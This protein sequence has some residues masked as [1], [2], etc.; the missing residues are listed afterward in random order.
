MA[1][2]RR[3]HVGQEIH[4]RPADEPSDRGSGGRLQVQRLCPRGE[5]RIPAEVRAG[6]RSNDR[7][8]AGRSD[9]VKRKVIGG[10]RY[11]KQV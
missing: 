11:A 10:N 5:Q 2:G 3:V 1:L 8:G 6:L 4:D 7:G 9:A